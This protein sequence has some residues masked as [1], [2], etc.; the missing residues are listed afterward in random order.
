MFGDI[1]LIHKGHAVP[2]GNW[3]DLV[4]AVAVEG[5]PFDFGI[6]SPATEVEDSLPAL[7]GD[8]ELAAYL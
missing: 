2:G 1:E 5:H 3:E 7:V 8:S 4:L 6:F